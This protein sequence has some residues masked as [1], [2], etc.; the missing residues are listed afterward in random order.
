MHIKV[1][2]EGLEDQAEKLLGECKEVRTKE[3][4]ATEELNTAHKTQSDTSSKN[5]K[6]AKAIAISDANKEWTAL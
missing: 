6:D 2:G 1:S 3:K 5:L 4:K